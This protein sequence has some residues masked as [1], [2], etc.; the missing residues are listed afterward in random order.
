MGEIS[1]RLAWASVCLAKNA[2][3]TKQRKSIQNNTLKRILNNA[4][5]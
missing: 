1:E 5:S 2:Q 3:L 4:F